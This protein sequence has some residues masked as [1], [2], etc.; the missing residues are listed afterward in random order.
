MLPRV[1]YSTNKTIRHLKASCRDMQEYH[2]KY[3]FGW[4]WHGYREG[5]SW[6]D[7]CTGKFEKVATER[8]LRAAENWARR[9][10]AR[11]NRLPAGIPTHDPHSHLHRLQPTPPQHTQSF[12]T[13]TTLESTPPTLFGRQHILP[14]Q[15]FPLLFRNNIFRGVAVGGVRKPDRECCGW[16]YRLAEIQTTAPDQKHKATTSTMR[17]ILSMVVEALPLIRTLEITP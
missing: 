3:G 4:E 9:F 14:H 2:F 13:Y 11:F 16:C 7:E 8:R 17:R 10:D 1:G 12:H 5:S 15:K 6:R